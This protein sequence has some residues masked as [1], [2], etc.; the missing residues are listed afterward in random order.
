[1]YLMFVEDTPVVAVEKFIK[2]LGDGLVKDVKIEKMRRII[3]KF[4]WFLDKHDH[5]FSRKG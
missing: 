3:P 4:L 1:M 5:R 2:Y